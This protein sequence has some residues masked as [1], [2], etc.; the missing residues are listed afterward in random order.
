ML[1]WLLAACADEP[2]QFTLE[3]HLNQVPPDVV[4][5]DV[6]DPGA[7]KLTS[8]NGRQVVVTRVYD[9]YES[10][11]RGNVI[12]FNIVHADGSVDISHAAPGACERLCHYSFCPTASELEL[13]A[14]EI[15]P[16]FVFEPFYSD[17]LTCEGGGKHS[18]SCL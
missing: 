17:C 16:P 3:L 11:R 14:L 5:V 12:T 7:T 10:A 9:D 1:V 6:D 2:K 18:V 4:G 15:P 13:E 8:A